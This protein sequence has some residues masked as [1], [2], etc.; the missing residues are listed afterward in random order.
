MREKSQVSVS[1]NSE[2]VF[3]KKYQRLKPPEMERIEVDLSR[4][5]PGDRVTLELREA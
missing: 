5:K 1:V 4:V 3:T 2:T